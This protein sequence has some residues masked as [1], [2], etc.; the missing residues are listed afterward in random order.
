M[1]AELLCERSTDECRRGSFSVD[2]YAIGIL[3]RLSPELEHAHISHPEKGEVLVSPKHGVYISRISDAAGFFQAP[4]SSLT[5]TEIKEPFP[6]VTITRRME[7]LL[8]EA[9]LHASQGRLIDG[10]RKYD[11]VQFSRWPNLTRVSLTPNVM[12]IC[13]LLTRYPSGINLGHK[14]LKIEEEEMNAVCSAAK[15]LGIVNLLNRKIQL[16]AEDEAQLKVHEQRQDE[17]KSGRLWGRL[18][19]KLTGL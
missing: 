6:P 15:I 10:L 2:D 14:F 5:V 18:F 3:M 4:K 12:R 19:A 9:A 17:S 16:D 8:W 11:V 1:T 7:D 13:A